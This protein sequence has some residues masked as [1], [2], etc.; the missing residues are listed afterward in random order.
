MIDETVDQIVMGIVLK[1]M[2]KLSE[3]DPDMAEMFMGPMD[4]MLENIASNDGFG[5]EAQCDPRGDGRNGE[6]TMWDIED[7]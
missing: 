5:T 7:N 2:I 1:R 4:E 6:F 3:S